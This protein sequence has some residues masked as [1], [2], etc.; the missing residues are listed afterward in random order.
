M[1]L[2]GKVRARSI[3]SDLG[4]RVLLCGLLI[5]QEQREKALERG[6]YFKNKNLNSNFFELCLLYI[7]HRKCGM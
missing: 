3:N 6:N 4:E 5:R 2:M 7:Y 1:T